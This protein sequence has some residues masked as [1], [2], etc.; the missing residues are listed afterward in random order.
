MSILTLIVLQGCSRDDLYSESTFTENVAEAFADCNASEIRFLASKHSIQTAFR[1][2]G[3]NNFADVAW[4]PDGV[5]LVFRVTSGA[6]LLNAETK[7]ISTIP[8]EVPTAD[9]AWLSAELLALPLQPAEGAQHARIAL[10]N[11]TSSALTISDLTVDDPQD[12]QPWGDGEQLLMLAVREDGT[13][14]PYR[15][16]PASGE[17]TQVFEFITEPVE[18]IVYTPE[19]ELLAWTAEGSTELMRTDGT[20]LRVLTGVK[21]AIP[22][23][24][25][26]YVMLEV[27]GEPIS[28]FDQRA[29]NEL[30]T[31]ARERELAR[32]QEF[33]ERLP[34]WA[35][36]EYTPPELQILDLEKKTRYRI[37]AFYGDHFEWYRSP[38]PM[39]R[40]F[41]SFVLWGIE[42][43][44]LNRNVGLTDLAERLRMLDQ[45]EL[46]LGFAQIEGDIK[47]PES[48][49]A[50]GADVSPEN[51]SLGTESK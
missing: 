23:P 13:R 15:F 6:Y 35:P 16:N 51:E 30:S 49:G 40:Y 44:Q 29:W 42:N 41:S 46:P 9:S 26:R 34:Q 32:Q 48:D 11:L 1:N 22:H 12:L 43:K 17:L 24:E 37:T 8:T 20:S 3:S 50:P 10:Y 38:N 21:R 31:A 47:A 33:V 7:T 36:R 5:H 25:G 2:C 28:P 19:A 39:A 14:W 18:R 45:G 4:A 27:D